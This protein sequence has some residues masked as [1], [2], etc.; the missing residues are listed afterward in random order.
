MSLH[1]VQL[2][3]QHF[4][5]RVSAKHFIE[6]DDPWI[7]VHVSGILSRLTDHNGGFLVLKLVTVLVLCL[8]PLFQRSLHF[9]QDSFE[10]LD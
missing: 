1:L 10:A 3:H 5:M 2:P 7:L 9:L 4:S 8:V 6:S